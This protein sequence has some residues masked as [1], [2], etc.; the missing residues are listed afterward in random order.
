MRTGITVVWMTDEHPY[1]ASV[2]D[3]VWTALAARPEWRAWLEEHVFDRPRRSFVFYEDRYDDRLV[4][5]GDTLR[6]V[7]SIEE[8]EAAFDERS[9]P[10]FMAGLFGDV[11][12]AW[13]E[14]L[15]VPGPPAVDDPPH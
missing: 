13:A 10:E 11:Y 7:V 6:Y 2:Q 14:T 9:L 1:A 4:I 3:R 15:G 8:V 12:A 5:R